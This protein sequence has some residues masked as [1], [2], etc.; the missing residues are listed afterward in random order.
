LTGK[1]ASQTP[2]SA[3]L[4]FLDEGLPSAVARALSLVGH[5]IT[6]CEEQGQRGT[7]DEL[8][9]PW[10]ADQ[11]YIWLTRDDAARKAHGAA[12]RRYQLSVVWVRGLDRSKNSISAIDLHLML[13]V[14]LEQISEKVV[15]A[16]GPVWFLLSMKS[17]GIPVL[18]IF[19]APDQVPGRPRRRR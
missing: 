4:F 1:A 18:E 15:A 17:G 7:K 3:P 10:L 5:P 2:R 14:K 13:T 12:L 6:S 19:A 11:G 16:R 8:L 9:I